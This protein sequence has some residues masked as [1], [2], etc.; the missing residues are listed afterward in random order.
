MKLYILQQQKNQLNFTKE[1]IANMN[2]PKP[3][4]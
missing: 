3:L 2:S 4:N 1:K